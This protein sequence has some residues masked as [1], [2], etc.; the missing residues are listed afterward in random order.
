MTMGRA[1]SDDR[2][3]QNISFKFREGRTLKVR[4]SC[5]L[6]GLSTQPQEF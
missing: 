3:E 5:V 4:P 6:A 1:V 2:A